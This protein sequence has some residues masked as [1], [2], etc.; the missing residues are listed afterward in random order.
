[1]TDAKTERLVIRISP[2]DKKLV[3][4]AA[5]ADDLEVSTW[6]RRVIVQVARRREARGKEGDQT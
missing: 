4:R 1:V 3:E 2:A 5:A 6:A